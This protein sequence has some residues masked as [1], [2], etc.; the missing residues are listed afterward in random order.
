MLRLDRHH[1]EVRAV[2]C[3]RCGLVENA[4]AGKTF[5][6]FFVL[7]RQGFDDAEFARI[8]ALAHQAADERSRHVA[9]AY[10]GDVHAGVFSL[11]GV[12]LGEG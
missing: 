11:V 1:D 2:D 12:L 8:G 3:A 10:E 9:A 4:D 6:E 5:D 7:R